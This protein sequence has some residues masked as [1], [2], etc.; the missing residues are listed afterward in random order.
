MN[1][2]NYTL[3]EQNLETFFNLFAVTQKGC[4]ALVDSLHDMQETYEDAGEFEAG[5]LVSEYRDKAFKK[6]NL[7]IVK[8]DQRFQLLE[9]QRNFVGDL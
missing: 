8:Q 9:S 3:L 6:G 7:L 1:Q 4:L 5:A 2:F